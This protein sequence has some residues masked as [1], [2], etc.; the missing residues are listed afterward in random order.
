M[1]KVAFLIKNDKLSEYPSDLLID[2]E[3]IKSSNLEFECKAN[4]IEILVG[5]YLSSSLIKKLRDNGVIF[6]KMDSIEEVKKLN[7][8]IIL[9]KEF[10]NKRG[11][12]CGKKGF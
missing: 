6:L 11:W 2:G 4:N 1:K 9:P 12:K 7:L 3:I 8:D 10:T 5:K